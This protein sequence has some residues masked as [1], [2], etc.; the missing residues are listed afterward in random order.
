MASRDDL[1]ALNAQLKSG[2]AEADKRNL[3][4][5]RH[6]LLR[7]RQRGEQQYPQRIGRQ[8]QITR[9]NAA[10]VGRS[11]RCV[12]RSRKWQRPQQQRCTGQCERSCHQPPRRPSAYQ[13]PIATCSPW[14]CTSLRG[15]AVKRRPTKR[16]RS[17]SPVV[18]RD[19]LW[20]EAEQVYLLALAKYDATD[21][22]AEASLA[23]LCRADLGG[24]YFD[25]GDSSQAADE[26]DN[27][28]VRVT[29][30]HHLV[31]TLCSEAGARAAVNQIGTARELLEQAVRQADRL[32]EI[33]PLRAYVLERT[34]WF[35]MDCW[36]PDKAEEYFDRA[37]QARSQK[38][39]PGTDSSAAVVS[40]SARQGDGAAIS[41]ARAGHARSTPRFHLAF[42]RPRRGNARDLHQTKTAARDHQS[43]A[44]H[45][46]PRGRLLPVQ[47]AAGSPPRGR[48]LRRRQPNSFAS[49]P[50]VSTTRPVCR[51]C[52]S[53]RAWLYRLR[54]T[55]PRPSSCW[56]RP[57][58]HGNPLRRAS[59]S[60]TSCCV[61]SPVR[62]LVGPV[63]VQRRA[64]SVSRSYSRLCAQKAKITKGDRPR[65]NRDED[66]LVGLYCAQSKIDKQQL[67]RSSGVRPV[68]EQ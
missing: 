56:L 64:N 12:S 42:V 14:C 41:Q 65:L 43:Q 38:A 13:P 55:P 16:T 66:Q 18:S 45:H 36:D 17:Q 3:A 35:Y 15:M 57:K 19:D 48:A 62:W 5:A 40:R 32:A 34:A 4:H 47:R 31:Y 60:G 58:P 2:D 10:E 63:R 20:R 33:D 28:R 26:F 59:A 50:R 8:R 1:Q 49:T 51:A 9:R 7:R 24:M 29:S 54:V 37:I 68:L 52:S 30:P 53:C 6:E 23:P 25:R 11:E 22:A 61:L 46:G 21:D 39:R 67:L 27:A 44:E